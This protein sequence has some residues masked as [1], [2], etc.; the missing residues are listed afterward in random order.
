MMAK[1]VSESSAR[2]FVR[3]TQMIAVVKETNRLHRVRNS[4]TA[5]MSEAGGGKM[6]VENAKKN[7]QVIASSSSNLC[8][9]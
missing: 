1:N 8:A 4:Q 3:G 5:A 7:L 9:R 2:V 6:K